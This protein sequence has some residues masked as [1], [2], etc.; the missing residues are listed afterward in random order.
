MKNKF[1]VTATLRKSLAGFIAFTL[2]YIPVTFLYYTILFA[3]S[4]KKLFGFFLFT[5]MGFFRPEVIYS[6]T[7]SRPLSRSYWRL[8]QAFFWLS[9]ALSILLMN[10]FAPLL[11]LG[12]IVAIL[13]L[14]LL[15]TGID[16]FVSWLRGE[17]ETPFKT[18]F[19]YINQGVWSFVISIQ[20]FIIAMLIFLVVE[21]SI[22]DAVS[23][24]KAGEV[25][26]VKDVIVFAAFSLFQT[27]HFIFSQIKG[28]SR[29][30]HKIVS[31]MV[32]SSCF[33]IAPITM[34]LI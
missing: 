11:I 26:S 33:M 27:V 1:S 22:I 16:P 6:V 8:A 21:P 34:S 12:S 24:E 10:P 5:L 2:I 7:A 18:Y 28:S 29:K 31:S 23:S 3:G 30:S 15:S 20:P 19:R 17:D 25:N 4:V 32:F 9:L 14:I 13:P